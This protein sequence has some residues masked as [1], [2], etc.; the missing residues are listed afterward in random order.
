MGSSLSTAHSIF[1]GVSHKYSP[2]GRNSGRRRGR[3]VDIAPSSQQRQQERRRQLVKFT[4][5]AMI[6]AAVFYVGVAIVV[7]SAQAAPSS[8][9]KCDT[10]AA[11][12]QCSPSLTHSWGQYS[13]FF[14]V[15]SAI[16]PAVPRTCT[17]T[18]ANILSRHGSRDP[19]ASKTAAYNKT[20]TKIHA[21]ATSYGPGY[22]FIR[23]YSYTLGADQLT[24][25]GQQQMVNS[26][27]DF[28]ARYSSL[29][30]KNDKRPFIRAS[31]QDRVIQSA[32]NFTQGWHSALL[33][34]HGHNDN[35]DSAP[36]QMVIIP[37]DAGFNNTMSHGLCTAFED[38]PASKIGASAQATFAATFTAPI[39]ARLAANLPGVAL[40]TAADVISFM[41]L[42]PFNTVASAN[43][44]TISPFCALFT[45]DEWKSYDYYQTLG[46][47]YGYGPGNPLGPTQGVGYVNELIARLTG[48]KVVDATS[49]NTTLDSDEKTFPLGRKLYADFSHDNDMAG[50][51]G[52]LGLYSEVGVGALSNTTRME[53]ESVKGWSAAWT[54]PFAGRFVFEKMVCGGGHGNGNGKEEELVRI[55]VNGRV[56]PLV[57]CG[58]D[59]LGRC[60]VGKFVKS[61][62]FARTGGRWAECFV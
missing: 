15:S 58:A 33:S 39:A 61:L 49:S 29:A 38:G 25:F 51:L 11:G 6:L 37:E 19:T 47:W 48:K 14:A 35:D 1:V 32:V 9:A 10:P 3:Y 36:Y 26:G 54:V 62:A 2:L 46:K 56:V 59:A 27:L 55:L 43:G 7:P 31:G 20:I 21:S 12:Y 17:L 28:Y 50:V 22:E 8:P 53:P 24:A 41:D 5:A 4:M 40:F 13:P 42:C 16:P 23:D 57:G 18:F 30:T 60:E 45:S 52:A 34:S 44:A